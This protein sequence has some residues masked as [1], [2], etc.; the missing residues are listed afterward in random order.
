MAKKTKDSNLSIEERLEQALIPNWDE[1]YKLP[2]NW[3]W[4]NLKSVLRHQSGNSKL[5]KGKLSP[6][7]SD[8]L[9]DAYSAS[10]QDVYTESY[11]HEGDAIIVS[12]VG[13]R[14]GKAFLASG[15]W[16]A[17]ANT[18][19]I[20]SND[21]LLDIRYLH[22]ILNDE[23]WWVKSGSAQP[24]IVVNESLLRPFALP[25]LQ[26]QQRIVSRIESMFTKLDEAKEKAQEVV[27]GFETRKAA[28]L[29]KAFSGELTAKWREDNHIAQD[30]WISTTIGAESILVTKGA[31]PR[32]QG[33]SYVDDKSQTLFITSE[34]VRE[35]YL[36]MSKEKYLDNKIN[37]IQKRSIL[38]KGD[39]LVNIVGA[40]IG[41][42]AIYNLDCLANIN[43]A[44]CLV[45]VKNTVRN[46]FLCHLLNSPYA[47]AYYDDNKVD[48][49]RANISLTNIGQMPIILPELEEQDEIILILENLL[50]KEQKAKEYAETVIE[51]IDTMKKA[52]LTRA[53]RG[54]LGTNDPEEE[55]AVELLKK[56]LDG[57]A[58]VQTPGKKPTK[59]ISI[60]S[61]IKNLLSNIREE[62]IIKLLLKA[63]P[64]PVSI[65]GIMALSSKKFELMDALRSLEKKQLITK[66][67]SGEYS[68]PR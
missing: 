62:E 48:V 33:V 12:A 9:Y 3:C 36:D 21:R 46:V 49:A 35:G 4:I 8:G 54:E 32:W 68:L 24:F 17:I 14:C 15:K 19:I 57:D 61:D 56:V 42:A 13:A 6:E 18:H 44:V 40:S 10:G 58:A 60:F 30:R 66:N 67:E 25:P 37:E 41:R 50:S 28:I 65:Q 31:S 43:Q 26:E 52:I 55:S 22:Y 39:V 63:S 51:Q 59:R 27:D 47:I 64:Q 20:Y 16:S 38:E 29:H 1:P 7:K 53:F 2:P 11:E 5:I 34:N 45:R 23:S